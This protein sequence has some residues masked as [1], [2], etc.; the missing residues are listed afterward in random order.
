MCL[1]IT[2]RDVLYI[3]SSQIIDKFG[4]ITY[5]LLAKL[6]ILV[7]GVCYYFCMGSVFTILIDVWVLG[8]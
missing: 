8:L 4:N 2:Q 3:V 1:F 5:M 6:A 7:I